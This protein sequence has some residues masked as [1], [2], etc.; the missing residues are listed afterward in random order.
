M[1]QA[2]I[3]ITGATGNVGTQ[4]V[5]RLAAAH[6]PFK[7]I[8]RSNDTNKYLENIPEAEIITADLGDEAAIGKALRGVEKAFLLTNSSEQ[9]ETL[10]L[11]FAAAAQAAG[12][13]HIVKLSQFAAAEQSPVRFL[14]YHARVENRIRELGMTYTFLRPNLYMQGLLGFKDYIR[15][16]GQFYAAVG[17]AA[18]S[19][20]DVRDIAAVAAYALT[21]P[22]H[23]NKIY[24]ITGGEAIT[25]YEMADILSRVLGK[26]VKFI[27]VTP[28]QMEGAVRAAGFPEWQVGGL[29]EDYA[30][31][32]RGEATVVSNAV[33]EVTGQAAIRFEQFVQD[34]KT[35]FA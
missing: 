1:T 17:N 14:R 21:K 10:Q 7:V 33:P 13:Q 5:K 11:N 25:H 16:D 31:Y 8:V 24:D 9:A 2:N 35:L 20:V 12:V 18:I 26:P 34:H 32:A 6:V 4:L 29:I 3:L 28:E 15:N 27:D 30:H 19:A 22:G 23:E